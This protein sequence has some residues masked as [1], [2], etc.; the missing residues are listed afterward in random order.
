MILQQ[1][2]VFVD[3]L[4]KNVHLNLCHQTR[5]LLI[6]HLSV[7]KKIGISVICENSDTFTLKNIQF[8]KKL[9]QYKQKIVISKD[10]FS[11]R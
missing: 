4:R 11:E 3:V 9:Q 8:N 6:F 5:E 2:S 7:L 10:F 1:K